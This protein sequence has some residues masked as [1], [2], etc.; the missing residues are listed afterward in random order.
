VYATNAPISERDP[1]GLYTSTVGITFVPKDTLKNLKEQAGGNGDSALGLTSST[2]ESFDK[3]IQKGPKANSDGRYPFEGFKPGGLTMSFQ[4]S[5]PKLS[6]LGDSLDKVI[7]GKLTFI[8]RHELKHTLALMI[9]G[10]VIFQTAEE[11]FMNS[12]GDYLKA[13]G[14]GPGTMPFLR[15]LHGINQLKG[16]WERFE[17]QQ[18]KKLHKSEAGQLRGLADPTLAVLQTESM[19]RPFPI[20]D[21]KEWVRIKATAIHKEVAS[22]LP[23]GFDFSMDSKL[24]VRIDQLYGWL[25]VKF[26][27]SLMLEGVPNEHLNLFNE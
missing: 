20:Q 15:T 1:S 3:L 5:L 7:Q 2:L 22:T 9:A 19:G 23:S 21:W 26:D 17:E 10:E 13:K 27:N 18:T 14:V 16:I 24:K 6:D 4:V 11:T 8:A 12:N 25:K